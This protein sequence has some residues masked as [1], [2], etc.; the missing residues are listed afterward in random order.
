MSNKDRYQNAFGKLHLSED[1]RE[2]C[3]APEESGKGKI[4]NFRAIHGISKLAAAAAAVCTIA[5]GSAGICYANDVGGIRTQVNLWLNGEKQ[6][7]EVQET[8]EGY[9]AVYDE[10]G[11][12]TM[13]FGGVSYDSFGN[14]I[15]M[16]AEELAGLMNNECRL[17]FTEDG[18]VMFYYKNLVEDVTDLIDEKGRLYIHVDDPANPYTYF[19]ITDI[20]MNGGYSTES[21]K[22]GSFGKDYYEVDST[23]IA[24]DEAVPEQDDDTSETVIV[25]SD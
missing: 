23:N 16:S 22:N 25:I 20:E 17:Y 5:L 13:G 9:Y 7:V 19:N 14:E 3:M 18:R 10:N 24:V 15:P 4:M 6:E 21:G 12:E 1:F 8:D 2:K 11:E